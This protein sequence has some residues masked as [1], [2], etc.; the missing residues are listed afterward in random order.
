MSNIRAYQV[1]HLLLLVGSNPLPNAVSG[2]LLATSEGTI[3]LIH[4]AS[5]FPLAQNLE[6]WFRNAGYSDIRLT[7]VEESDA[8][9][10]YQKV[11]TVLKEY[12]SDHGNANRARVGLNYTG[13]TKV[14]A[15]QAH[16]AL[17]D[18]AKSRD[19]DAVFS[20]LDAAT[21]Q[22]RFDPTSGM[23]AISLPVGLKVDISIHDL[24]KLHNWKLTNNPNPAPVLPESAAALLNILNNIN[25]AKIWTK[26]LDDELFRN[27]RKP[28][29]VS[30]PFWVYQSGK[31]LQGQYNVKKPGDEWKNTQLQN[32]ALSWPNLPTLR[33]IMGDELGQGDAQHLNLAAARMR[34]CKDEKDFCQWLSGIWLESAVL[35]VLQNCSEELHLKECWMDLKPKV[36]DN[37]DKSE[38]FQFDVVAI[39]GY[40]LFA[41]S[42]TTDASKGLLKQ[43]LFEAY[44]RAQ[45]M[46]GDEAC[47]A[48]VCCAPQ[49]KVDALEAEMRCDIGSEGRIRVFGREDLANLAEHI[50]D[51]VCEQSREV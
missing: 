12:E 23:P 47:T 43:K 16:R 1:D 19:K 14:M 31:E 6:S 51:W 48:L 32:L 38:L 34:G 4:S 41:F 17:K 2:K 50:K 42:C 37:Q 11:E 36:L 5:S 10:V 18:W 8:T 39:R 27:A 28:T 30:S 13:G 45:Q 20:Y 35:S 3:T 40:Q 7:Q 22:M 33:E 49:E 15:V 26:W 44:V 21:L 46:G 9:P 29:A 24:L 25:D